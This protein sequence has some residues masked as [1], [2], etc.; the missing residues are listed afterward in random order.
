MIE[1]IL[2]T[3]SCVSMKYLTYYAYAMG[4]Y[5]IT[6]FVLQLILKSDDK[7]SQS[8]GKKNDRLEFASSEILARW[9]RPHVRNEWFSVAD[10]FYRY[11][12]TQIAI[13][14]CLMT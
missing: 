3:V 4:G 6:S 8:E 2:C 14:W 1:D 7:P 13:L 9:T 12:L 5:I 11:G 10:C